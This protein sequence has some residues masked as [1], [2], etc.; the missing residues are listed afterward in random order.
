MSDTPRT[1]AVV[2]ELIP[3]QF[4]PQNLI[5]ISRQLEREL[6][7]LKKPIM[8]MPNCEL[9][10]AIAATWVLIQRTA[11]HWAHYQPAIEHY[12]ALLKEQERRA[13]GR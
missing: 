6:G 11:I 13:I 10:D 9:C 3:D 1:D 7:A 4:L 5:D 12:K 2:D 8:T